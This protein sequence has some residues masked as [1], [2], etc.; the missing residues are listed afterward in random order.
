MKAGLNGTT[1]GWIGRGAVGSSRTPAA[2]VGGP[3]TYAALNLVIPVA[4]NFR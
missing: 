3:E 1:I 2:A 4:S